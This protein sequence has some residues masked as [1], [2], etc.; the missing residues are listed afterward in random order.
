MSDVLKLGRPTR[1]RQLIIMTLSFEN[2]P[3]PDLLSYR[4]FLAF[5]NI[6]AASCRSRPYDSP[7]RL[8][9]AS[10]TRGSR[11]SEAYRVAIGVAE[12]FLDDRGAAAHLSPLANCPCTDQAGPPNVRETVP[13][14]GS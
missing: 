7:C 13:W 6:V 2:A 9:I 12:Y 8:H 3:L 4:A 14:H 5:L 11:S 10:P 1:R